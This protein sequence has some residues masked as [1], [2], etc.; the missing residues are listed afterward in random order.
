MSLS[1]IIPEWKRPTVLA[2]SGRKN[3]L[4]G[5]SAES[6]GAWQNEVAERRPF[7]ASTAAEYGSEIANR[8][9]LRVELTNSYK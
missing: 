7:S 9:S 8:N 6:A 5:A 3:T 1:T 4:S 2:A